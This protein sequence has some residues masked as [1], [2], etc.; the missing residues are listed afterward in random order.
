M[1]NII[2]LTQA[3]LKMKQ[4]EPSKIADTW[5][6]GCRDPITHDP[7]EHLLADDT[8]SCDVCNRCYTDTLNY[9]KNDK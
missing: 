1:I 7:K 6:C 4:K 9:M 3:K 2:L 8:L 5:A